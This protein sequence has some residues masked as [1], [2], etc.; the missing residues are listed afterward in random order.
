MNT[1][2]LKNK[3]FQITQSMPLHE[4]ESQDLAFNLFIDYA[5]KCC[6]TAWNRSFSRI[7]KTWFSRDGFTCHLPI[8]ADEKALSEAM[9]IYVKLVSEN[10]PFTDI[11][12]NLTE[13]IILTGRKGRGKGEFYTPK[14]VAK[15]TVDLSLPDDSEIREF[16]RVYSVGDICCGAGSLILPFLSNIHR[17]DPEKLNMIFVLLNDIDELACKSSTLQIFSTLTIFSLQL[18]SFSMFKADAIKEYFKEG[19]LY[20]GMRSLE[21]LANLDD[22]E[23]CDYELALRETSSEATRSPVTT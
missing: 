6:L 11:L 7:G 13:E 17:V 9:S 21:R 23:L 1:K 2:S 8:D 22:G 4:R 14:A 20:Y 5:Y 12:S 16:N 15:S 10:P 18:D 19:T 3:I